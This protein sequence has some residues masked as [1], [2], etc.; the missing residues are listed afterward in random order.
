MTAAAHTASKGVLA[1]IRVCDF[2]WVG[3]G[4][5][6]T[7]ELA[8]HGA[9]VI[10]IESRHRLDPS[11]KTPPFV[12]GD[13]PDHSAFFVMSNTSKKSVAINLS[14]PRGQEVAKQ[15]AL[16]SHMVVE[17]FGTG[18]ME[19]IGLGWDTLHALKPDLAMVSVSIAGRTGPLAKFRGYGN[20]AAAT[21]GQ[22]LM[23][24]FPDHEPHLTNYAYGDVA[25]PLFAAI[26][27]MGALDYQRRTGR[28][29]HVD[30]CQL[31]SM[32]QLLA[33][34]FVAEAMGL[35]QG[36]QG[37]REPWCAPNGVFP[38]TGEDE[39][40]AVSV[41]SD[42]DWAAFC[43]V[44]GVNDD[45]LAAVEARLADPER[46]ESLVA[47][48]TRG[49]SA[50][51]AAEALLARGIAAGPVQNGQ[52]VSEDPQLLHRDIAPV[53]DHPAMGP[54]RHVAP[55]FKLSR[56]PSD[57]G[58]APRLGQDTDHILTDLIGMTG[59]EIAALRSEEVL[60]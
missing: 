4:P 31:E 33:P 52:Q 30:A 32:M 48:W 45:D 26:A 17:N 37:N 35:P 38:C 36:P 14:D 34:A 46:V 40:V 2:S 24:G 5:R 39:W 59:E 53:M 50:A 55:A 21:S 27:M 56:T 29:I 60:A 47:D 20:S 25:T 28:G 15:I 12:N 7:K 42:E 3:A 58:L 43:A 8:D 57:V 13:S 10:K 44:S 41:Q 54:V 19:R 16:R 49:R 23:T 9:E 11:R 6:A 22:A 18:F 51:E 1:G